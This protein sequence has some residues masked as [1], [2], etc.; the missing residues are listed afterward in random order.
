MRA[1]DAHGV[2][3][4][5][6]VLDTR[7][8]SDETAPRATIVCVHGNPTWSY[9]WRDLLR[10]GSAVGY[11][12]IALDHL[13]MGFSER[14]GLHRRLADRVAELDAVVAALQVSGETVVVGH[15]WGGVVASAWATS[16]HAAPLEV[17]SLVLTNT[18]VTLP[19]DAAAP[20]P[21]R[22]ARTPGV[23]PLVTSRTEAFLRTTLAIARP[24]LAD[25]VAAAYRAPYLSVERRLGIEDFVADIPVGAGHPTRPV[26][27]AAAE[28]L[29][30]FD[31]P[32]LLLWGP[33]D[34]VFGE[35]FLRDL[36]G[37]LPGA[38]VHRFAEAGHLVVEDADVAGTV[39][40]WLD[41]RT[42]TGAPEGHDD[43][44]APIDL[45]SQLLQRKDSDEPAVVEVQPDG[46]ARRI[47]WSLLARRVDEIAAG[48]LAQGVRPG[49]RISLLVPPGADLTAVVYATLRIGA[50]GVVADAGLGVRGLT[51]AVTSSGVD[52]VIGVPKALA[53]ARALRW[54]GRRIAAGPVPDA[55]LRAVGASTTVSDLARTGARRL[56]EGAVLPPAPGPEAQAVVLFT[57]GST[58]PAKGVVYNHEQLARLAQAMGATIR[59][60]P[61]AG[62]VSAFAPFA[63][64]GP[65]LGA[66]CVVPAMDV[67]RPSTLT[68]RALA[69]A[70]AASGSTS[71]FLSPAA[72]VNVLATED[73]LD[74]ADRRALGEVEVLLS[75]GAP[76]PT[77]LLQRVA[78]LMPKADP[79]TPYGATE[80]LP[81]TDVGLSD[82][83]EAGLGEGI[84][85][86][87]PV[88]GTTVAIAP[89]DDAGVPGAD[90][91]TTP[92][93]T[94]EVVVGGAHVKDHY[95]Q[96][97]L[98][99]ADSVAVGS[100]A[101]PDGGPRARR[102]HRTGDVGHLDDEGRVWIEGR[103][104]HVVRTPAGVLTP[105]G[106]EQRA[107]TVPGIA[108]AALVGIGPEHA[109]QVAVVAEAGGADAGDVEPVARTTVATPELSEAVRLATGLPLV[110]VLLVPA[111][112]TDVRHNSKIDRVRVAAWAERVLAGE[113]TEPLVR[114]GWR[115]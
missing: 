10:A 88:A 108:R 27:E 107:E 44:V 113:R 34:P 98:T 39:L 101:G 75:A 102:W 64:L 37:R 17:T 80:V 112:P 22:L 106:P 63:L 28:R 46:S 62:L 56:A 52:A 38:D 77:P 49:Q 29:G 20:G 23:L 19:T 58:G 42:D 18:G 11:R 5:W 87:R 57:S 115:R 59:I 43:D 99:Q 109:R 26:F 96:L 91:V 85:V 32:T 65:A 89:L 36:R 24:A 9:L 31:R 16:P 83:L 30:R 8:G 40:R 53:A 78:R 104:A 2:E 103:L 7:A 45:W 69:A 33:N 21:V 51:R 79:R 68:A 1:V 114:K 100:V 105:V 93:V 55:V 111:L 86:G 76:V 61:G 110:A 50:V 97:W 92:G 74:P 48:L 41:R 14:T 4:T 67:T 94:G 82:I 73:D 13:E 72:L 3:R 66:T 60:G 84:C 12:V 35:K 47:G 81:A 95:D 25:D 54:P 90:L 6:H 70:V 71:V 15:D